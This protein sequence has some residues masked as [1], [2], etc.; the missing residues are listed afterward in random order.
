MKRLLCVVLLLF[1]M[2]VPP[3]TAAPVAPLAAILLSSPYSQDFNTLATSGT[4]NTWT[5]DSTISGWYSTRTVYI[6][7]AGTTNNGALYSFG[8]GTATERALGSVASG[9]TGTVRYGA[10]FTN[11]TGNT[12]T[13]IT[14]SYTGEQWRNGGNTS[15]HKLSFD[16]QVGGT[17]TSLTTGTWTPVT[18]L[19][20]TGPIAVSTA[21]ALDGNAA[22]NRVAI[23]AP[24][25]VSIAA[26]QEIMLRWNDPDDTGSDH[27]LAVDDL[28]VTATGSVVDNP[29]T[30]ASTT[31]TSSATGVSPSESVSVTFSE[32]VTFSGTVDI[33]CTSGAPQT[34]TP[35]ATA[36]PKIWNLP[37]AD[38]TAGAVCSITIPAAQVV[39]QDGTKNSMAAPYTWSFTVADCSDTS[40]LTL[41]HDIQ[42]SG[43][44]SPVVGQPKTIEGIVVGDYETGG[45]MGY[46]VQEED[47]DADADLATSEG[48]FVYDANATSEVSLGD[49]VRVAGTVDESYSLTELKTITSLAVCS[50]GQGSLVKTTSVSLPAASS[51][52]LERYEGM[53]VTFPQELTVTDNY[54][55]GRYGEL[56][57]SVNGKLWQFTHQNAPDA[58]NYAAYLSEI[59]LRSIL[60]DDGSTTQN[61]D[62]I[63][64]PGTGL[65]TFNTVRVD[66]TITGLTGVLDYDY[67]VYRLQPIGQVNFMADNPRTTTPPAVG[68]NVKVGSF[69]TL[70]FFVTLSP[71]CVPSTGVNCPCGPTGGMDCRGA[72]DATEF[73]HQRDKLVAAICGLN[74]DVLGLMELENP[75]ST[76][77]TDPVLGNL[78][79]ALNASSACVDDYAFIDNAWAGTD[80]IRQGIIYKSTVVTPVGAT[81][82]LNTTAFINGG[83][84]SAR[85]RPALTQAFEKVATSERFIVSVNH[86][87]SKGSACTDP[88]ALDGQANCAVV[89]TKAVIELMAWLATNPTGTGDPD[90]LIVGDLNSYAKEAPIT[91]LVNAGYTDLINWTVGSAGYGYGFDGMMG[92]L[93]H[94]LASSALLAQITAAD[95]W[96][97]NSPEP[98]VLDYNMEFKSDGQDISLYYPDA[99]RS[100]DHDPVLVGLGLGLN[101]DRSD[102]DVTTPAYGQAWHTGQG[103]VWKLGTA[104]TGEASLTGAD[105]SDD[106]VTRGTSSWNDTR[107]EVDVTVTGPTGKYACLNAWLDYSDGSVVP[108]NV[109]TPD[110]VFNSNEHVVNN[111]PIQAGVNQLVSWPLELGVINGAAQY[112]MRFRLVPAPD[113]AVASCSG[114]TLASTAEVL[115]PDG[116][117]SPTGRADGGEVEDYTWTGNPTAVTL[118][119]LSAAGVSITGWPAA[120]GLGALG[121]VLLARR[122][123]K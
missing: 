113:P 1:V 112:N 104:W 64:Y 75:R 74:A 59:A 30:V 71:T 118:S 102:L 94:A 8:T 36:D 5:D 76:A 117:A 22:A 123:R 110:G 4:T 60:L 107:G 89:R 38:F 28:T 66:D 20:F 3:V 62:P 85:N 32:A 79:T 57:L 58:I 119:H 87:K 98:D 103:V 33:T 82:I 115:A 96:H 40:G 61:L 78:V 121:I 53:W 47:S 99:Y 37:H 39:D 54:D 108:N 15:Q 72:D 42:G 73:T 95:E 29:P 80:A 17:V 31:P 97:I 27:G 12:I 35:A 92:Y 88:D 84:G 11:D 25:A 114:V 101:P 9:S 109:E 63:F 68:G 116:G 100:T 67:G 90:I 14:V 13:S 23:S 70:N 55:L 10:R 105:D 83:D 111:L 122:R 65:T 81:A 77:T 91:E 16:Y 93:D 49:Q 52:Y 56:T 19:D 45:M 21:A 46:F 43:A 2:A 44:T 34:V 18:S 7:N 26:G 50:N 106:G 41:I 24:F 69:N 120:A 6:A 86:L 51:T 48:I